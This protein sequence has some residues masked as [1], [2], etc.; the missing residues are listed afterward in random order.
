MEK[1]LTVEEIREKIFDMEDPAD[2]AFS[3]FEVINTVEWTD[4]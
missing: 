3:L 4:D 2:V 1:E